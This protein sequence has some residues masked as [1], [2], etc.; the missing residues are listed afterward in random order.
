MKAKDVQD[1]LEN[2]EVFLR[3]LLTFLLLFIGLSVLAGLQGCST[4]QTYS[5]WLQPELHVA[6]GVDATY[7]REVMSEAVQGLPAAAGGQI[8]AD[9]TNWYCK[10]QIPVIYHLMP[11]GLPETS[12]VPVI[13]VDN[14]YIWPI[15]IFQ[16]RGCAKGASGTLESGEYVTN[17]DYQTNAMMS[18]RNIAGVTLTGIRVADVAVMRHELKHMLGATE[19]DLIGDFLPNTFW[20]LF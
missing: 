11:S 2:V 15:R 19:Q 14:A 13:F 12:R 9:E 17:H 18:E 4:Q 1:L 7:V 10:P 3:W 6:A 20:S 5:R 8:V 16:G